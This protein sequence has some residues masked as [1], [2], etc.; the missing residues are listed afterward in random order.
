MASSRVSVN[1]VASY[2]MLYPTREGH[3]CIGA[4]VGAAD[5][6]TEV[7]QGRRSQLT[8]SVLPPE[9]KPVNSSCLRLHVVFLVLDVGCNAI[10]L[11]YFIFNTRAHAH[12]YSSVSIHNQPIDKHLPRGNY[13]ATAYVS[14]EPVAARQVSLANKLPISIVLKD[15]SFL[16]AANLD[17]R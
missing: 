3:W 8:F 10:N 16:I 2:Y 6:V 9:I 7:Q 13:A 5:P 11:L 4:L 14:A 15:A 12:G 1:E 17:T